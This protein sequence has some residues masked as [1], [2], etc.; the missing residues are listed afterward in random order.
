MKMTSNRVLM[1]AMIPTLSLGGCV[2]LWGKSYNVD[3]SDQSGIVL[4]YDHALAN[5]TEMTA[6][7]NEHCKKYNK[8]AQQTDSGMPGLM[9]GI[10]QETYKCVPAGVNPPA[11]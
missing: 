7:A 10:I 2:A 5:T 9:V 8:L 11:N 3:K 1:L 4:Q 6:I